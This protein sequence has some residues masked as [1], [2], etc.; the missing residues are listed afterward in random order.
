VHVWVADAFTEGMQE[1]NPFQVNVIDPSGLMEMIR[2]LPPVAGVGPDGSRV[3]RFKGNDPHPTSG[4]GAVEAFNLEKPA[5][6]DFH[7][8]G[9]ALSKAGSDEHP[10]GMPFRDEQVRP[11]HPQGM[12]HLR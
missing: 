4:R 2:R 10:V 1:V 3:E 8:P 11:S 5:A 6:F 9:L 12:I 7:H